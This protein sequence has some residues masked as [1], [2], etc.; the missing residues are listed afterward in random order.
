M[1]AIRIHEYGDPSVLRYE[2][3]PMPEVSPGDVLI[4]VTATSFNPVDAKIRQGL[5]KNQMPKQLPFVLGWDCAG[6]VEEIGREVKTLKVGDEVFTMPEFARGGAYAEFVSVS[7]EQVE[8]KPKTLSLLESAALPMTAQTALLAIKT[9]QLSAGQT[10]LIHGGA[11]GV[12]T[13][14]IQIAKE[15]G[16]TVI[17]TASGDD[18]ELVRSLG[19]D[20]AIDYKKTNFKDKVKDVDAVLD[21]LGGKIQ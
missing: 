20:E 16:A 19:A 6:V 14:A 12:G 8:L 5:L 2:D 7:E 15:R 18:L 13:I 10:I 4:R 9:A 3:A 11:G 17:T 21:V 1:K